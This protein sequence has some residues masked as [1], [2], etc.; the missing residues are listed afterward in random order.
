VQ[1][2]NR[3]SFSQRAILDCLATEDTET[4]EKKY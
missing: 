1:N 3:N 4:T 2:C